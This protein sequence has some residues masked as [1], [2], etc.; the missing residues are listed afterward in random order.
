M[1]INI[2]ITK[3]ISDERIIA[4]LTG[5]TE[6][7]KGVANETIEAPPAQHP[8]YARCGKWQKCTITNQTTGERMRFDSIRQALRYIGIEAKYISRAQALACSWDG[9]TFEFND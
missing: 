4:L 2:I 1:N 8:T 3:D 9:W 5:I 6:T 7:R